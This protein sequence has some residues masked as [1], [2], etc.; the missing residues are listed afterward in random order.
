MYVVLH[1]VTCHGVWLY[2]MHRMCWDSSSFTWHQPCNNKTVLLVHHFSGGEEGAVAAWRDSDSASCQRVQCLYNFTPPPEIVGS[3]RYTHTHTHTHKPYPLQNN[4]MAT[5]RRKKLMMQCE[6]ISRALL[7]ETQ[8]DMDK[9]TTT[10]ARSTMM[11]STVNKR[12]RMCSTTRWMLKRSDLYTTQT[13]ASS[14][15]QQRELITTQK[16]LGDGS[17]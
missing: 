17:W 15:K 4:L 14:M 8:L 3:T 10:K 1:E 16:K 9:S 7:A 13:L 2:G 12:N 11:S 6:T 5:S